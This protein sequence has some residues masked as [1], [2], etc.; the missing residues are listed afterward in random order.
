MNEKLLRSIPKVD[1]VL[2][3]T[4]LLDV[5]EDISAAALKEAVREVLEKLRGG[6]L[7][8]SI[9]EMPE[10]KELCGLI[11]AY[12]KRQSLPSLRS[13]INGTG[14][15]LHTNLGRACLSKKA[16]EALESVAKSYSTLEYDLEAGERG[17][18]YAH[19][20][21]A[22]KKLTGAESALVVNNNAAAVLLILSALASGGEVVVSRGELVEIGGSFRVPDIMESC[23]CSLHEV[24]T[25]NKTYLRDYEKAVNEQTRALLKVHTSNY[26]IVGFTQ[27][28]ELEELVELGREKS[29]PVI[30]DMGSGLVMDLN[31]LGIHGEPTVKDSLKAGV[32]VLCFSGD[33]LLGGPQAGIIIGKKAYVDIIK[34]HPLNRAMR[35]GKLTLCALEATLRSYTDD[36]ALEDIP[37]LRMLSAE[38]EKLEER[39]KKLCQ[40]LTDAGVPAS[41]R[42]EWGEVGGGAAPAQLLPS[43][44]VAIKSANISVDALER[45]MRI[46][47]RPII[48]RI[49][50]DAYLLDLRTICDE[51]FE[52]V[53]QALREVDWK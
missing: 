13:V 47:E 45:H 43:F 8:G 52:A 49:S 9:V 12:A 19:V 4:D 23:G 53:L 14:V 35:V 51:D 37:T 3:W 34:K 41:V 30:E 6:A 31:F 32:D 29:L 7:D 5:S 15:V 33:K 28:V 42:P 17:E 1:E 38:P 48:G 26:R 25:T 27:S 11:A 36:T 2:Q 40:M 22:L 50:H 46:R 39:A 21:K 10:Q 44:A 24:G 16:A 20:E 18:R